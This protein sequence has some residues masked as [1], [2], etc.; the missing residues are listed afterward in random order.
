MPEFVPPRVRTRATAP[1]VALAEQTPPIVAERSRL[2]LITVERSVDS[3]HQ[4]DH[5]VRRRG[6]RQLDKTIASVKRFG[7][8]FPILIKADGE[9]IKGHGVLE[10]AK[11]L[12]HR[13]VPTVVIDHLND[14]EVRAVRVALNQISRLGEWDL[15]S[16][17]AEFEF[18]FEVDPSLVQFTGFEM[19]AIDALLAPSFGLGAGDPAD[20][21]PEVA[22]KA[23]IS[24]LGDLWI[25][26]DQKLLCGNARSPESYHRLIGAEKVQMLFTDGPYG[27]G[28]Q[29]H[30]S[31]KHGEF[32]EGSGLSQKEVL[33]FYSDFLTTVRESLQNGALVYLCIDARSMASLLNAVSSANLEQKELCVWD[34]QA[35]GMGS[36]Y[37]H[38]AEFVVVAKYG[39]DSH[40]NNVQLGKHGRNR[41]TI[42]SY[43]GLAQFGPGRA[44][45]LAMHPTVKPVGLVA[46][47]ILD[48]SLPGGVVLDP[49]SGSGTTLIAAQR[50]RRRG[51]AIELDPKYVDIA[52]QRLEKF[53]GQLARHA[54]TGLTFDE[55]A[56]QRQQEQGQVSSP[57]SSSAQAAA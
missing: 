10:A 49:F 47:A 14:A 45:A 2:R 51:C 44:Q 34:K 31:R 6:K 3:I 43:P 39:R 9:V 37:R 16:L 29:G 24:C 12:G 30:V 33:A 28:I 54:D 23:A 32:V 7:L 46:D 42:W 50:T 11:A 57:A 35:G 52:V 18:L 48:A 17:K 4:S 21:L 15:D 5:R 53:T 22:L 56:Q 19:P 27:C 55:T 26:A 25:C 1:L 13:S 20:D 36:L 41:T 38:Q 8:L 40:I